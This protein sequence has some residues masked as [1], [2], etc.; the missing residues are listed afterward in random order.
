MTNFPLPPLQERRFIVFMVLFGVFLSNAL[1]AEMIGVKLFSLEKTLGYEPLALHIVGDMTFS[2]DLSVGVIMWPIVF[3]ISD[4]IN[5]YFGKEGVYRISFITVFFII[6]A[7]ILIYLVTA[8][9]PSDFWL[10]ANGSDPSGNP[11]DINYAFW[12]LNRQSMSIIFASLTAFAV[13]QVL[14][15]VAFERIKKWTG[16]KSVWLRATGSTA[17]SQLVDSFLILTLAFYVLGNWTIEQ[18]I[19]VGIVQY[20]Y[21]MT[22][23]I[24][25]IPLLN[26][27]HN[28]IDR[29]LKIG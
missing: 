9:P 1:I 25:L 23:A 28:L 20:V 21:K 10:K 6:Y 8:L 13:G 17:F 22:V 16:E 2:I 26:L 24:L 3:I 5:E 7:F 11:F 27:L 15:A 14:D 19:S 4:V 18:V 29:Y 12:V